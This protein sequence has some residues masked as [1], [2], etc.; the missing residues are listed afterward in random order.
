[1][2]WTSEPEKNEEIVF[3]SRRVG[4]VGRFN[5]AV[6]TEWVV[7]CMKAHEELME[8]GRDCLH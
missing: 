8:T 1:M 2:Q 4:G 5:P 6:T 3:S 7:T